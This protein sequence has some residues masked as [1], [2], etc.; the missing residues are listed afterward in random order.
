MMCA[1]G[2]RLQHCGYRVFRQ[3]C[4]RRAPLMNWKMNMTWNKSC[5][6]ILSHLQGYLTHQHEMIEDDF[7]GAERLPFETTS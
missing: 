4:Q 6:Q 7:L 1:L 2:P 5:Y 3:T